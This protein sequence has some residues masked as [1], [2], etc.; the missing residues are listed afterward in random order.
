MTSGLETPIFES[1]EDIDYIDSNWLLHLRDYMIHIN[2]VL[3]LPQVWK[4]LKQRENDV[5][6]MD[7]FKQRG[8]SKSEL[9]L[10]NNWRIFYQVITLVDICDP[11]GNK[12]EKAFI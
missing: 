3:E 6:L 11:I 7:V 4:I 12:I 8:L 9:R 1:R 2:A 10:I 5:V